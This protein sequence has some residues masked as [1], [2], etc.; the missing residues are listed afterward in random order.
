MIYIVYVTTNLITQQIYIGVHQQN[1]P[2]EFDGYIGSGEWK[3]KKKH[4]STKFS[5]GQG[6]RK[7]GLSNFARE[8]L[9]YY[10]NESDAY[11]KESEIVTV[12]FIKHDWNYNLT[13][14]GKR[15]P[16]NKMFGIDNPL[17]RTDV[18]DKRKASIRARFGVDEPFA[19]AEVIATVRSTKLRK[20][21]NSTFVN[22]S[23]RDQTVKERYGVDYIFQTQPFID[24]MIN[25]N[26]AKRPEVRAK[27]SESA[28][29]RAV[30]A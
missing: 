15:P 1:E 22:T 13:P 8:T 18:Q 30:K 19:S 11:T 29:R 12:D 14:G 23:K 20:Y 21:G 3:S 7:F 28:K 10:W 4:S 24:R 17:S 25:D 2:Y 5:L 27:M 16:I 26:P 9:F 6:I